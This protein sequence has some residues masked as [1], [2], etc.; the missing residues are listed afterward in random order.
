M[1]K[2]Y[3]VLNHNL[4]SMWHT[5]MHKFKLCAD[6]W[7]DK[8]EMWE[9]YGCDHH[10]LKRLIR[11]DSTLSPRFRI[12]TWNNSQIRRQVRQLNEISNCLHFIS[13]A[14][15]FCIMRSIT[16]ISLSLLYIFNSFCILR[17]IF[18]STNTIP[19]QFLCP[20][21]VRVSQILEPRK[22]FHERILI[23]LAFSFTTN[24]DFLAN[25]SS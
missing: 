22:T 20:A 19:P 8:I 17:T 2:I 1:R 13:K 3:I 24:F 6:N 9:K 15:N 18:D 4:D 14:N 25:E 5:H 12:S 16:A 11:V 23:S 10:R 7:I 21:Y